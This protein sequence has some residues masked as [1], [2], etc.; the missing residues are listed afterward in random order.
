MTTQIA[1][2][3]K[4]RAL[5]AQTW[6]VKSAMIWIDEVLFFYFGFVGPG[7]TLLRRMDQRKDIIPVLV[8]MCCAP[9]VFLVFDC[10]DCVLPVWSWIARGLVMHYMIRNNFSGSRIVYG[11]IRA[12]LLRANIFNNN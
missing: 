3:P 11:Y 10:L 4:W 8:Y 2:C 7:L 6:D 1:T 9:V 5:R 12:L